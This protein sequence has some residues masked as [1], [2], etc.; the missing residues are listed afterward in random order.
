M[1]ILW[2]SRLPLRPL[3][4][5]VC[6]C[7]CHWPG[8]PVAGKGRSDGP[9]S[10]DSCGESSETSAPPWCLQAPANCRVLENRHLQHTEQAE[11]LVF[12]PNV[13]CT[14]LQSVITACY[15][16]LLIWSVI[17]ACYYSLLL[18]PVTTVCYYS[19]LLQPV[20]TACYY[21][22]LLQP[23]ITICYYSLITKS[24]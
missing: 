1:D 13:S 10:C 2:F 24:T 3:L 20:V 19:L 4:Q 7:C 5:S 23:V 12:I 14:L 11:S 22:L 18:Q 9:G 21:H 8:D 6:Q 17:T 15:Y 16:S